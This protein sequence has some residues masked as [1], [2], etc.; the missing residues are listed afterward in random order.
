MTSRRHQKRSSK[1]RAIKDQ[2][3]RYVTMTYTLSSHG[4]GSEVN[5]V[6]SRIEIATARELPKESIRDMRLRC[7][8]A[9]RNYMSDTTPQICVA[10]MAGAWRT[11]V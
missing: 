7:D 10:R 9:N 4:V 5:M 6:G 3:V 8:I 2:V 1:Y 11:I